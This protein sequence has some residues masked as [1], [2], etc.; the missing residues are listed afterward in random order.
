MKIKSS[1]K[2]FSEI[3]E[4]ACKVT[5]LAA[6]MQNDMEITKEQYVEWAKS[7]LDATKC[8]KEWMQKVAKHIKENQ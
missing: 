5:R 7:G 4:H 6:M 8:I 1:E 3:Y 2:L